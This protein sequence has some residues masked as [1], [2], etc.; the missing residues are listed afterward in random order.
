MDAELDLVPFEGPPKR[1]VGGHPW[2]IPGPIV[3]DTSRAEAIGY[4]PVGGYGDLV[5]E[6]CRSAVEAA[7]AGVAFVPYLLTMFDYAAEGAWFDRRRHV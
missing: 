3:L 2:C 7:L 5:G 4:R 6:A 1:G